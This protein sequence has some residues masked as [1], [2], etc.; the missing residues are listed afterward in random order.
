MRTPPWR[1]G[2]GGG[3]AVGKLS[4]TPQL[5]R[6]SPSRLQLR[7]ARAPGGSVSVRK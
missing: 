6:T 7:G 3:G 4:R 5:R 1:G 2:A